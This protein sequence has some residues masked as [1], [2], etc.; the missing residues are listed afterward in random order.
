MLALALTASGCGSTAHELVCEI[1]GDCVRGG[2]VGKCF[3][4]GHCAF[5][6]SECVSGFRWDT[7]AADSLAD[8]CV[9]SETSV[10]GGPDTNAC[11]GTI[12]LPGNPGDACGACDSG[13]YACNG[14]DAVV[15]NGE[16]TLVQLITP[17]GSAA[18]S[19]VFGDNDYP[20]NLAVDGDLSTSWF[21]TGPK[22][23]G[24]P[25]L[26][27]WTHNTGEDCITEIRL[28]GNGGNSNAGFRTDF[29][30]ET[31]T[32]KIESQGATVYSQVESM[33]GTPDPDINHKTNGVMGDKIVL[34]F[35][36]HESS[37]CG[38]Y[39]ELIIEAVR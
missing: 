26:Y 3:D 21:S 13:T 9:A 31:V 4:P 11:G 18:A 17:Q 14:P 15:C 5:E 16:A 12:T 1:D 19:T 28:R 10:D 7:S 36:G 35:L 25:T 39:A 8:M 37:D 20:A 30:F 2:D 29:G 22:S 38:G 6:D 23:G 33:S 32:I 34:E 24:A 27:T